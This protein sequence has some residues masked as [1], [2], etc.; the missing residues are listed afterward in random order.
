MDELISTVEFGLR[1]DNV[2]MAVGDLW[3]H[4]G[5]IPMGGLSSVQRV[6]CIPLGC[7]ILQ[8]QMRGLCTGAQTRQ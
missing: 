7:V 6:I 4:M 5:A 3:C 2:L 8:K 1:H